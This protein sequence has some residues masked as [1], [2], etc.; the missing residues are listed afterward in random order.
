MSAPVVP[1]QSSSHEPGRRAKRTFEQFQT[2]FVQ[3]PYFRPLALRIT[4]ICSADLSWESQ[5][6]SGPPTRSNP[7]RDKQVKPQKR[8]LFFSFLPAS[9]RENGSPQQA[10]HTGTRRLRQR[11]IRQSIIPHPCVPTQL[12]AWRQSG[13][14]VRSVGDSLDHLIGTFPGP[15][16]I[17]FLTPIRHCRLTG[18]LRRDE[19]RR[20]SLPG[21]YRT[22][23]EL[24]LLP[25]QSTPYRPFTPY[26]VPTHLLHTPVPHPVI[27]SL[28]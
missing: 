20:R 16:G 17:S 21:R 4:A 1:R 8:I 2:L 23:T 19:L 14:I 9:R 24:S 5:R 22:S 27:P 10:T 3:S 18:D 26:P 6:G 11:S 12:T 28:F 7:F 13:V 25:T 15:I